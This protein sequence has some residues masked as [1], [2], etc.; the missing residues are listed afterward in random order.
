MFIVLLPSIVNV[1]NHIKSVS[2]SNQKLEIQPT[3]INLHCNERSQ[4]NH[5]Y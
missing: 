5:Y 4:E 2:L 1:S 3:F